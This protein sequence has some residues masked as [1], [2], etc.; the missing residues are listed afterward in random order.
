MGRV[1]QPVRTR[2][3][4]IIAL[5]I[6]L[7]GCGTG[8]KEADRARLCSVSI[9]PTVKIKGFT[10]FGGKGKLAT[11][12]GGVVAG[13]A[14]AAAGSVAG[15]DTSEKGQILTLMREN[16]IDIGEIM[17]AEF[18]KQLSTK[19]DFPPRVSEG[20]D[21]TFHFEIGYA[22]A[23][24]VFSSELKPELYVWANLKDRDDKVIWKSYQWVNQHLTGYK[25]DEYMQNP[26]LLCQVLEQACAVV[27]K[28]F[29]KS[30]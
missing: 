5:A 9:D 2:G 10:Y 14:G 7:G 13:P 1:I 28:K 16:G 29:A 23:Q 6:F 17:I 30:L 26:E 20:G 22:L 24:G 11:V 21:A 19:S 4:A 18:E 12:V 15:A 8:L 3:I 27:A 25:H